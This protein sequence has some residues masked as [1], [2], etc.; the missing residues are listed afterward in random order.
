ME[1]KILRCI[2]VRKRLLL[3]MVLMHFFK[4]ITAHN[5]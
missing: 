4:T 1:T 2:F 3:Q 5:Y